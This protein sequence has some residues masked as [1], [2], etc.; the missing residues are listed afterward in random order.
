[1]TRGRGKQ[2]EYCSGLANIANGLF[3]GMGG[4]AMIGQSMINIRGGGRGRSSG[5]AAA[6]FLTNIYSVGSSLCR[7]DSSCSSSWRN[8][9]G[10]Y[11]RPLNGQVLELFETYLSL[12]PLSLP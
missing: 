9:Y 8:V 7:N 10:S 5:I 11:S 6:D 1:M 12:M 2:R 3:G 4:C